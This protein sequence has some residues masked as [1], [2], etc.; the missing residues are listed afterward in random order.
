MG[1]RRV[2][3]HELKTGRLNSMLMPLRFATVGVAAAAVAFALA[4]AAAASGSFAVTPLVSDNGVPKTTPDANL[5]NS[6]G[7]TAS[8]TGP[9]WVADN[10]KGVSTLYTGDGSK[11]GLTVTVG[12]APTG[13]VANTTT[14]FKLK[15]G[16]NDL[17]AF[18]F[19]SE[20]GAI[21]AWNGS[22]GT[23]AEVE[24]SAPGAVFK[25]LA[26][27]QTSAGPRLYASD[28]H[29]RRVDVFDGSWQ[30]INR[31]FQFFDP[32]IPRNYGPLG[33]QAIGSHV[34]VTYAKTQPGSD[35]EAHGPGLGFVDSFNA[36]TG[37]LDG[38]VAA[39]G[40]LNAPFGL[41]MAPAGFG[42]FGGDLLV[43]NFGD[44][45]IHAYKPLLGGLAYRPDGELD[46]AERSPISIDDL[47]S[48]Q[49]GNGAAAGPAGTLF[50]TSGPND[51][52]DGLF[53][54]ITSG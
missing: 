50:F 34:F 36:A 11:L 20:E 26:I 14:G 32:T 29:N 6:W 54:S 15:G 12:D 7:L 18:V 17:S 4:A 33:I 37:I 42:S 27:S 43:G 47:W 19:D 8:P 22:L 31:P 21:R 35:D 25:G 24:T 16:N 45:R 30:Q 39:R 46:G 44:G 53:G 40:T 3:V 28:F 23:T 2:T 41:A 10:G 5:V 52:G 51:E 9:W 49:F 48:L 13:V 1:V 38:K